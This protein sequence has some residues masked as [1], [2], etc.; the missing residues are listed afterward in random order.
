MSVK[1]KRAPDVYKQKR[2]T[3]Y[4][5][6]FKKQISESYFICFLYI[7]VSLTEICTYLCEYTYY[8]NIIHTYLYYLFLLQATWHTVASW[9]LE[10]YVRVENLQMTVR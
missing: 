8:I 2:V 4:K 9:I 1:T 3:I 5:I 6:F 10:Y 7:C